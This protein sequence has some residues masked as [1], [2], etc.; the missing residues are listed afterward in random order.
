MLHVNALYDSSQDAAL[1]FVDRVK[2]THVLYFRVFFAMLLGCLDTCLP[3]EVA[4]R[5][6]AVV[7]EYSAD[8]KD[9]MAF[10]GR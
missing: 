10:S 9:L 7:R 6:A 1:F 3:A 2:E 8:V 4:L 5:L